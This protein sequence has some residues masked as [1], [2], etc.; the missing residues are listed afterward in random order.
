MRE[1]Q[2]PNCAVKDLNDGGSAQI[3][4]EFIINMLITYIP[5]LG[6]AATVTDRLQRCTMHYEHAGLRE[7][8]WPEPASMESP[9]SLSRD[10]AAP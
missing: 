10:L 5:T 9:S 7:H 3:Q 1:K 2:E 8:P 4:N 6:F